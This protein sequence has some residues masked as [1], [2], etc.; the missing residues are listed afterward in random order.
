MLELELPLF[1][2]ICLAGL[3]CFFDFVEGSAGCCGC[4]AEG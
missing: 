3:T 4:G 1:L 2:G